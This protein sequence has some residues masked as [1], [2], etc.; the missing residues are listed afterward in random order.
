MIDIGSDQH[1]MIEVELLCYSGSIEN[2]CVVFVKWRFEENYMF[3]EKKARKIDAREIIF[4]RVNVFAYIF[5]Q[6]C[7]PNIAYGF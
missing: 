3:P 2:W 7:R 1:F 5:G 4:G 6:N